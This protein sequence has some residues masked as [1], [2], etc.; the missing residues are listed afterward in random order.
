MSDFRQRQQ[1]KWVV[2]GLFTSITIFAA[3]A[4][5]GSSSWFTESPVRG[6]LFDMIASTTVGIAFLF[7]PI[8]FAIAIFR[9]RLWDIDVLINRTLVYGLLTISLVSTYILGV[10]AVQALLRSITGQGSELAVAIV[11]LG[12]AALFNPWRTRLQRF[13]DRRFYRRKYDAARTL[14]AFQVTLRDQVDMG[15][16][17]DDLLGVVQETMQP[18]SIGIQLGGVR[19]GGRDGT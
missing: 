19:I 16:L 17:S 4:V 7:V 9:Y 3:A 1:I 14:A 12:I 5:C 2:V 10:I 13:I 11:T 6:V 15:E 18:A 8:A